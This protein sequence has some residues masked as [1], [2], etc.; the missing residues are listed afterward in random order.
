MIAMEWNR[1]IE[2]QFYLP[3][4]RVLKKHGFVQGIQD[5]LDRK[6][7]TLVIEAPPGIR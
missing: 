2:S 7:K 6:I 5:L 1:P 4:R 3:R